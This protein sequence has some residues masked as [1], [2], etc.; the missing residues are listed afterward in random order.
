MNGLIRWF[1]NNDVAANL[2]M[3]LI[4]LAG[5]YSYPKIPM[6]ILPRF[7]TDTIG[8]S[9]S[10]QGATPT[11][12]EQNVIIRIEQ[13]IQDLEGIKHIRSA[14]MEGVGDIEVEVVPGYDERQMMEDIKSRID[15][16]E[17]FPEEMIRPTIAINRRNIDVISVVVAG[18]LSERELRQIAEK[19]ATDLRSKSEISQ[20]EL[21]GARN[22]EI[23]IEISEQSLKRYGLSF[24]EI[25]DA[26][27]RSSVDIPAGQIR[28]K[29]GDIL[30]STPGL[31]HSKKD[32][33]KIVILTDEHGTRLTLGEIAEINDGFV[34]ER[35]VSRYQ[36]KS[37]LMIDV[38]RVNSENAIHIANVV[39][40]Y[41]LEVQ[42]K[43]PPTVGIT[44]WRDR[45]KSIKNRISLLLKSAIQGGILVFL[46]LTLFLRLK[47]AFWVC[48]GIPVSFFGVI[49]LMPTIG[50]SI[51][52]VSTFAFI[53]VLGIIVDDAI[54]TGES[55]ATHQK[56]SSN[57]LEATISGVKEVAMPVTFGVMT[58][59]VAFLPLLTIEGNRGKIFAPVALIIVPAL[60]FSLLET[61][62]ILPAHLK[63]IK[64]VSPD[65]ESNW[66]NRIQNSCSFHLN[67][68]INESYK[69]FLTKIL[70]QRYLTVSIF[71]GLAMILLSL[72][73]SGRM[74]FTFFPRVESEV[75]TATVVFPVGTP[76]EI[77]ET[78][79]QKIAKAAYQLQEKYSNKDSGNK[80]IKA[81]YSVAGH[82]SWEGTPRPH[83]GKVR[84]EVLPPELRK[85]Y[86]S[87]S[88]L[89]K[90]WRNLI[91]IIPGVEELSFR[92]EIGH[93]DPIDIQIQSDNMQ[94]LS[95]LAVEI[96]QRLLNFKGIDDIYDNSDA[97]KQEIQLAIKPQAELLGLTLQDLASQVRQ[98]FYGLEVQRIQRNKEDIKVM[99]RYPL[100]KRTSLNNLE[101]M[102]IRTD[103]G[104]EVPFTDVA[105][106][107][108]GRSSATIQ[109]VDGSRS[110]NIK[111]DINKEKGNAGQIKK[112]IEN[113]MQELLVKY[114]EVQYSQE[115]EAREQ[116]ESFRSLTL[117]G[118][119]IA[120]CI[121]A[122]LAIPF[123]SYFQP[124]VVMFVIPFGL[125]GA[126]LGHLIMNINLSMS[127]LL[128]MLALSG[129]VINDSLVLIDRFNQLRRTGKGVVDA[130][131]Q[132]GC[133]RFRA[134][135]LTSLT[136]FAGLMPLIFEKGTQAQFL[137]PMAVSLGYG[138][139]FATLITL[140]L[141]PAISVILE[142]MRSGYQ[143]AKNRVLQ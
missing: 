117:G 74:G 8:I 10:Y 73:A 104:I 110:L 70:S 87:V 51:N 52:L 43:F 105:K 13:E 134:I 99:L 132:A 81:V 100:E 42:E 101:S 106:V 72:V 84:F 65:I 138:I 128:G 109:R 26:I 115:G 15:N 58:T 120:V 22:Y 62:L 90:E 135:L 111:A 34:E 142:D 6:E 46:L 107:E 98:A 121:Y 85:P 63:K 130:I 11:E 59:V 14:A 12:M 38:T 114:P 37:A 54:V 118:I 41:V 35:V 122:L 57:P 80:V 47:I 30:L 66:L 60:L 67:Q 55:I 61:K 96:K 50:V 116:Q 20:V 31:A 92:S 78:Y 53:M 88:Q 129:V 75:A 79:T 112:E 141:V 4:I 1:T 69:P 24:K 64:P 93:R 113:F 95:K 33:A 27:K 49:A 44:Y 82:P 29:G 125:I 123:K 102:L 124:L 25:G 77:N 83:V 28:T 136:T 16:I 143:W 126:I 17:T 9:L 131:I 94:Q 2:L 137:I 45:S 119:F 5:L 71:L 76:F 97:G 89:T 19:V 32:F 39:K 103:T 133:N 91:G 86:V 68:F 23:S 36:G 40:Q 21:V 7:D 108:H 127:S 140:V 56:A 139:L 48:V 18:E 3:L